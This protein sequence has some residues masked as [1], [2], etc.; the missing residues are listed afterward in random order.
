MS[1]FFKN[2]YKIRKDLTDF[3][4]KN[5]LGKILKPF[6]KDAYKFVNT[7]LPYPRD[8][9]LR[10]FPKNAISCEIG[11]YEGLFSERILSF[12]RPKKLY[13]VDPWQGISD[14]TEEKYNQS[15]QDRRFNNVKE[16]LKK[17]ID[18]GQ[19]EIIRKTS[20]DAVSHFTDQSL[21]Y[22]YIDGDHSYH[23]VKKDLEN[24]YPK[25][26][27]GGLLTGDDYQI[28]DVQKAVDEFVSTHNVPL[29]TRNNQFI[30]KKI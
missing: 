5:P 23:Q 11:V 7:F 26:K 25:V 18:K 30:I 9:L 14:R 8:F 15:S 6:F 2:D 4:N 29:Q 10:Q 20:D 13:L 22:I 19:I 1:K 27:A 3:A 12:A 24:F 21:D 28:S 17:A 16:L